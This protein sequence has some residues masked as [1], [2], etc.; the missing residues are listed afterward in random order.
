MNL[1]LQIRLMQFRNGDMTFF[2]ILCESSKTP[3]RWQPRIHKNQ[4]NIISFLL[5]KLVLKILLL[6]N[7]LLGIYFSSKIWIINILQSSAMYIK[8]LVLIT[9]WMLLTPIYTIWHSRPVKQKVQQ[10]SK[11]TIYKETFLAL[12]K[13]PS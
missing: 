13:V 3:K 12:N 5:S 4:E 11:R 10:S 7:K 2:K 9:H 8:M 1:W 6:L